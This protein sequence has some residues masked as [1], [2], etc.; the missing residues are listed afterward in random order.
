MGISAWALLPGQKACD[1]RTG[2]LNDRVAMITRAAPG[3]TGVQP[4]R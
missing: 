1:S 3:H 2:D 4:Q